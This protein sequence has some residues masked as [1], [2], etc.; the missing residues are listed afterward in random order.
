MTA[1]QLLAVVKTGASVEFPN[2][3]KVVGDTKSKYIQTFELGN[4]TGV[5]NMDKEG[6]VQCI[7]EMKALTKTLK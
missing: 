3:Y 4:Y 5:W 7:K 6:A 2:G 1:L